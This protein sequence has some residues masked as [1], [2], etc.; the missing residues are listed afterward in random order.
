MAFTL[1]R[2]FKKYEILEGYYSCLCGIFKVHMNI[3]ILAVLQIY[4]HVLDPVYLE[5][6]N[7]TVFIKVY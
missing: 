5:F 2:T 4:A 1:G 7:K 3:S 6:C